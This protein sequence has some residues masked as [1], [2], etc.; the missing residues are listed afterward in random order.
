MLLF[1]GLEGLLELEHRPGRSLKWSLEQSLSDLLQLAERAARPGRGLERCQL[2]ELA[3]GCPRLWLKTFVDMVAAGRRRRALVG[4][5]R[6]WS[7][8]WSRAG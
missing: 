3:T 1:P 2:N 8:A 5:G 4:R 6:K 7:L